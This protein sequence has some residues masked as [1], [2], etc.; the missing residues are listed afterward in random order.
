[1]SDGTQ[2]L[3]GDATLAFW[4]SVA[5]GS[6]PA[7]AAPEISVPGLS[8]DDQLNGSSG[9]DVLIGGA[10]N[11]TLAGGQG[12]DLYIF[13]RG[14]GT[15]VIGEQ[16][17]TADRDE[18]AFRADTQADELWFRRVDGDLV[19]SILGTDDQITVKDWYLGGEDVVETIRSG[20]GKVLNHNNVETLISA[21][22]SFQPAT[23]SNSSGIQPDD[24]R[25]GDPS[26]TGTIAAA[27][28]SAWTPA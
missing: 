18:L 16:G 10:G 7:A 21:M 22:A 9:D 15:D 2:R 5:E 23:A 8:G 11:D 14:D 13:G 1:M 25:M 24:P 20:D 19:V 4:T 26:Q 12:N 28:A 17:T 27:M 3:V 6:E